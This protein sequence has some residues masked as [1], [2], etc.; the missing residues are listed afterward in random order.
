MYRWVQASGGAI[1]DGAV[2]QGHEADGESLWVCRA[3]YAGGVHPGKVRG[4]FGA[5]NIPYGGQEVKVFEYEV[6]MDAGQWVAASGGNIPEGAA[7]WGREANGE[8][9]FVAR[10]IVVGNDLHPGKVRAEFGAANIPYGGNEVK[11]QFYD[12]LVGE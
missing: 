10:A 2:A 12:V 1:P 6:L 8:G 11:V 4:A 9:L 3:N 5:A 7:A